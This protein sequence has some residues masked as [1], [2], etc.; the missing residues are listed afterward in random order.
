[1]NFDALVDEAWPSFESVHV[2]DWK[3]RFAGGVTKRA[4][5]AV[6]TGPAETGPGE[7]A[8]IER[9]YRERGMPVVF[10]LSDPGL[11]ALLEERGYALAD[12]TLLMTRDLASGPVEAPGEGLPI[13]ERPS[14]GWMDVWWSVDGRYADQLPA[15]ERILTGV[16]ARYCGTG[17]VAVG[18]SVPQDGM[19]GVYCMAVRPEARRRGLARRVLRTLLADGRRLGSSHAYLCVTEENAAARDLYLGEGFEIVGGYR[20]RVLTSS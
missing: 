11:D 16:A 15:A 19:L 3:V 7:L 5:S 18:R 2:G 9:L 1:M 4:N 20:Y 17:G 14:P 13:T 10:Q 12:P 8:E 6:R